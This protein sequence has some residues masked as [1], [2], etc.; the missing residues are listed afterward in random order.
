MAIKKEMKKDAIPDS[1][2]PKVNK[3]TKEPKGSKDAEK[4]PKES[5]V[6]VKV[7]EK[8]FSGV[9][10]RKT[11]VAIVRI[12]E[13]AK[14]GESEVTVNSKKG[15]EYFPTLRLQG[16]FLEPIRTIGL[17]NKFRISVHVR[18]GGPMGQASAAGLGLARAL[19]S[20]NT[21]HRPLLKSGKFLSR[22]SRKVERKKPGLNKAR[23]APQ[24]SKR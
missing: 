10:R 12:F 14:E 24:W 3:E 6:E 23:R 22:D 7:P 4:K 20:A 13:D 19:V 2:E 9:G 8:Y 18:G 5:I 15:K 16:L 11:A 21:E 17:E 1:K